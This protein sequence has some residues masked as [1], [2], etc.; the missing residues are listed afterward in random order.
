[1]A[2]KKVRKPKAPKLH[3]AQHTW[4]NYKRK[5]SEWKKYQAEL[6]KRRKLK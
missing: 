4:D 2:L 5:L 6:D 1:M 3:A